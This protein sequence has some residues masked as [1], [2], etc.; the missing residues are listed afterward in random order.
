[1]SMDLWGYD[2]HTA[3][4]TM[5]DYARQPRDEQ[6][7]ILLHRGV[8]EG[9]NQVTF[10]NTP[11]PTGRTGNDFHFTPPAHWNEAMDNL[12]SEQGNESYGGYWGTQDE[13]RF[14][15]GDANGAEPHG[16]MTVS[17]WWH[18]EDVH[19]TENWQDGLWV[20]PGAQGEV[21]Q[22]HVYHRG[23]GWV[24]L[25]GSEGRTVT[26][27][28]TAMPTYYHVTPG[29]NEDSIRERGLD[30]L[31]GESPWGARPGPLGYGNFFYDNEDAAQ[32]Y[33]DQ[34]TDYHQKVRGQPDARWVVMPFDH[35]GPVSQDPEAPSHN[36]HGAF[37]TDDPIPPASFRKARTMTAAVTVYTSPSCPQCFATK[38]HL[39]KLGIE[40]RVIDVTVDPEAHA[41]V[42]G[43][44]YTSAP[45]V[46]AGED[47]WS[48]YR[49]D[50]LKGLIGE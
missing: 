19:H 41:Y 42:T 30:H 46:V 48:G 8:D 23:K 35:E 40:H 28:R 7:R 29:Q 17:S 12:R 6:G 11:D 33:A 10:H 3:M 43:L 13:A 45:V 14:Y 50:R 20:H 31:Q 37:Y 34:M 15:A 47:H 4:A 24:P 2:L 9:F 5:D 38:K 27:A 18:P 36:P 22:A 16:A 32:T 21:S 39:D 44:G 1:M 26:A 49:P 25:P